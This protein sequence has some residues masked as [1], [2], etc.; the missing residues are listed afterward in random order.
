MID[1]NII[2]SLG[3]GSG[4][5][6]NSLVTQ[7]TAIEKAAPQARIDNKRD[8]AQTQISDFGLLSSAL[9]TLK[10]AASV[11]T[12]PEGLFS[13]SASFTESDA[14]VPTSL[15]TDVKAGTYAFTVNQTAQSQALA[16]EGFS[17]PSDAVGEG[18]VTLNFG[19]WARDV[20]GDI[21][22]G[23]TQDN[24]SESTAITIDSTNNSLQGLRDAINEAD[25]GVTASIVFDGSDYHLTVLAE[26]GEQN[27]LEIVVEESGGSPSNTDGSDLSRFAF[28]AAVTGFEN[29]ETQGG[30]DAQLTINGLVVNRSSN[31]ITDV[32]EGITLDILKATSAGET[33][34]VTVT[35]DKA[36]AEQNVRGFVDAYN[37]FLEA[38]DPIFGTNEVENDDGDT[39]TVVGSLANDGL[40]K[41]ALTQIRGLIA[42]SIPG[43]SDSN[44]TS[45]TNIG[46]RTELD[47]SL[48]INEKDFNAAFTDNFE[49]VQKLLAPYTSSSSDEVIINSFSDN[50]KSGEY[51]I[52][53]TQAPAKGVYDGDPVTGIS[54]P[55]D[56]TGKTYTFEINVDGTSSEL[57]TIPADTYTSESQ[58]AAALQTLINTDTQLSGAGAEV[59]VGFNS[60]SGGFDIVSSQYGGTSNVSISA[61]S[62]DSLADLGFTI[63]DGTPGSTTAGTIDGES[64]FGSANVLLPKLGDPGEGL[65]MIIGE[66]ATSATVNFSR[67]FAGELENLID[68]F[69]SASGP[70]SQRQET[71]SVSIESLDDDQEKLDR[72]ISSY[73]E[74]LIQQYIAMERILSSLS[75][76]GSFLDSLIDTLPFTANNN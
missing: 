16:F 43:L 20:D 11:L 30:R 71:L 32:V 66:N 51:N 52:V 50:T 3:A 73:E 59:T 45:L 72:R 17:D 75:S 39:E 7:L 1:N 58:L 64:G 28:S 24:A 48:S 41:S 34:T 62:A 36:F 61:A 44:L 27:Q 25:V 21:N 69:L 53:I 49:D 33:V 42:S 6:T 76:S 46:I 67:G 56:T 18:T 8:L 13:K 57:L 65:A 37:A 54:F 63:K 68:S 19:A 2:Q 10:D 5:D 22:G 55:L 70:I 40:A 23:F 47:G 38:V 60:S 35:D 4:I 29:S 15:A 31:T 14:L 74:R 9:S 26:S 12:E